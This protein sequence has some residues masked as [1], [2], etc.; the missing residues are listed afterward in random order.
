MDITFET[1]GGFAALPGLNRPFT[2]DTKAL[3][4]QRA[5]ELES[6]VREA[7]F[8][9]KPAVSDTTAKGAADYQTYV[10]TVR[11]GT[12]SH[13]VRLTDPIT[14]PFLER[15]VSRLRVMVRPPKP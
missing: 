1:S 4:L 15:L 14:D 2:I 5:G 12:R 6:L 10:I 9:E 3:D 13:T 8:F 7:T 11:D